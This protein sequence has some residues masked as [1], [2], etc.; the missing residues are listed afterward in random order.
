MKRITLRS[1][2]L[3]IL[4][5]TF[6]LFPI[7]AE[8]SNLD[9]ELF[10]SS[11]TSLDEDLFGS[12]STT[13]ASMDEDLFGSSSSEPASDSNVDTLFDGGDLVS[14]VT[15]TE[16]NLTETL[17]TNPDGVKIGGSFTFSMGPGYTWNTD[18]DA[19]SWKLS[20]DMH[21]Q[22]Y[23]DARPDSSIRI[24]GKALITYPFT[25]VGDDTSTPLVDE[26]RTFSDIVHITE[27]FSDFSLDDTV[28]FR[29]GKQTLNWGVG[30]FFSPANLLN[31]SKI[32]PQ[33]P[34]AELEGPLS[35]KANMPVGV[36]NLYGYIILPEDATEP[37]DLAFA[38]KYEKVIAASEV[39][40]GGY[41]RYGQSPKAMVTVSSAIKDVSVFAEGVLSYGSDRTFVVSSGSGYD[42]VTYDDRLFFSA[43]IGGMYSWAAE[44]GNFGFSLTGQYYYNGEGYSDT[45]L[46]PGI[47]QSYLASQIS[48]SDISPLGKQYGGA[49]LSVTLTDTVSTGVFWYGNMSDLSGL[50]RPS[51]TWSPSDHVSVS[52][53]L[54]MNYGK[55]DTTEFTQLVGHTIIPSLRIVLGGAS[56]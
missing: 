49:N 5:S 1:L 38:A 43:T 44:V 8:V 14:D 30:Y 47:R 24:F 37:Q 39:G 36:D 20:T 27:L 25:V 26:S 54:D 21:S 53:S 48:L 56:F 29:V 50:V 22:L 6:L 7:Y 45:A 41:Y 55:A 16:I 31:L 15:E 46:Y 10:G 32:D 2:G 33:D 11:D 3:L 9:A 34:D 52:F 23:F 35:I 40:L 28:F 13:D 18:S 51:I 19:T 17:L 12:D 42:T 4:V